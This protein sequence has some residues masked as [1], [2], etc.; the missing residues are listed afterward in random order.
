MNELFTGAALDFI[1][2]AKDRPFFLYLAYTVPHAELRP[3]A[4]AM[5]PF[6]GLFPEHPFV[7]EAAD[8]RQPT[9]ADLAGATVPRDLD[10]VSHASALMGGA[11]VAPDGFLYWE[12]HERGVVHRHT[13]DVSDVRRWL[14]RR[15][16]TEMV[17]D[18]AD[19]DGV[20]DVG[21]DPSGPPQRL[22]TR[23]SV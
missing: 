18:P 6:R 13:D 4:E 12:F 10:G 8:G 2:R 14:L 21:N 22:Q 7:N 20:G 23:G 9:L 11:S 16:E 17:Q 5:A 1:E 15:A 19:R 3:P